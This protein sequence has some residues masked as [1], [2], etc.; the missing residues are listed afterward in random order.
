MEQFSAKIIK[1]S[2]YIFSHTQKVATHCKEQNK[3]NYDNCLKNKKVIQS[4][5]NVKKMPKK[6]NIFSLKIH[7]GARVSKKKAKTFL[8]KGTKH[9]K[10]IYGR[11]KL[12]K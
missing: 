4:P 9:I 1:F 3:K 12:K 8:N 6:L 5:K 10:K 11:S 2:S 7:K